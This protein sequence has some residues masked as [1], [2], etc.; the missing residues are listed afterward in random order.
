MVYIGFD[1]LLN[2]TYSRMYTNNIILLNKEKDIEK[3]QILYDKFKD[4]M[5][6][7]VNDLQKN[8]LLK[9]STLF[10]NEAVSNFI[11][12]NSDLVC[13]LIHNGID[14][15]MYFDLSNDADM[16][17]YIYRIQH[18]AK[19]M[20]VKTVDH[21]KYV[22]FDINIKDRS[23]IMEKKSIHVIHVGIEEFHNMLLKNNIFEK[24]SYYRVHIDSRYY[25]INLMKNIIDLVLGN[26][27]S[28][29][30]ITDSESSSFHQSKYSKITKQKNVLAPLF[31]NNK[32][33]IANTCINDTMVNIGNDVPNI[34]SNNIISYECIGKDICIN[35]KYQTN[36]LMLSYKFD[37]IYTS[38][39]IYFLLKPN[40]IKEIYYSRT[41][42]IRMC[43][44]GS[45]GKILKIFT[46][47]EEVYLGKIYRE[48]VIIE[49]RVNVYISNRHSQ[50]RINIEKPEK[51]DYFVI[52]EIE[53]SP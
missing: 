25:D 37:D 6:I 41:M 40:I 35:Y 46:G 30:G 42:N 51:G 8:G 12:L 16:Y 5:M 22:F 33:M 2:D 21:D 11:L 38:S 43:V 10:V 9:Y 34:I 13:Q 44:R 1:I 45:H 23:H 49:K 53:I 48:S 17:K 28:S 27:Q 24:N 18:F 20:I 29:F 3:Q 19:D 26:S 36:E 4:N 31:M 7:I 14:I 52:H 32:D 39:G 50:Y 15:G 47:K